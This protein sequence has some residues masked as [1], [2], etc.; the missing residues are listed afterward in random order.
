M[1]IYRI[2]RTRVIITKNKSQDKDSYCMVWDSCYI[3]FIE[4]DLIRQGRILRSQKTGGYGYSESVTKMS[5]KLL[6][7]ES[8]AFCAFSWF[9]SIL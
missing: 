9:V 7:L 1:L 5:H 4:P 6:I 3:S 8:S 2:G